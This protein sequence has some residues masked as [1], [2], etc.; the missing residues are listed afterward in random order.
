MC[1]SVRAPSRDGSLRGT[2]TACDNFAEGIDMA[3]LSVQ[4]GIESPITL[5]TL[6]NELLVSAVIWICDARDD[7]ELCTSSASLL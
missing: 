1:I 2:S 5:N 6:A 7:Y 4:R 3:E